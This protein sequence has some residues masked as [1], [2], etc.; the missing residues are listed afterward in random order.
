VFLFGIVL[1]IFI[2][3]LGREELSA[4]SLAR[5]GTSAVLIAAGIGLISG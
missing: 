3:S 2:P 5:K 1:S 4:G